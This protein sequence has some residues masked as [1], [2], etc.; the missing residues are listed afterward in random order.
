L[1]SPGSDPGWL[2]G[3]RVQEKPETIIIG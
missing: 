2:S 1:T 3:R